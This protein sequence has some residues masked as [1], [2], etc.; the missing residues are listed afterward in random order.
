MAY[1]SGGND[2]ESHALKKAFGISGLQSEY[3]FEMRNGVAV[4]L[5]TENKEQQYE[6]AIEE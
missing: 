6:K 1:T 4:P 5:G 2:K 3:D